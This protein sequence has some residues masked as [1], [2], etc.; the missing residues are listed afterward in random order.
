I[1]TLEYH[2]LEHRI[3]SYVRETVKENVQIALRAPLLQSFKELTESDMKE[4]LQQRMFESG[5]YKKHPDY[6]TLYDALEKSMSCDNMEALHEEL[7]KSRKGRRDGQDPPSPPSPQ[8]YND[9]QDPP[10]PLKDS[11]QN[12]K[13]RHNSNASG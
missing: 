6:A 11:D 2:D 4:M 7:S 9:D 8:K 1:Y 3:N 5:S 10:T 12:K 13:R